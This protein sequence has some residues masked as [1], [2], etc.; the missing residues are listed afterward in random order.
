MPGVPA[1][2][3]GQK[4]NVLD[5]VKGTTEFTT[6]IGTYFEPKS[7]LPPSPPPALRSLSVHYWR[8][9]DH[10][11]PQTPHKEDE[12]YYVLRGR[13]TIVVNGTT[14]TLTEGDV[15]FVPRCA[16]HRFGDFDEEGLHLLVVF[17]PEYSG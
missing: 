1:A 5:Y 4:W 15:I 13:G 12:I 16:E 10:P 7:Q 2:R 8:L 6:L 17:S 9:K 11:D 14:H 3:G